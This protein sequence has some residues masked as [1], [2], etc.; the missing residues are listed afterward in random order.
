VSSYW[1]GAA[2]YY[3]GI[4]K[5]L[6]R[7]GH[8]ITFAEPDAYGRQEHRDEGDFSYV[9]SVVYR[10]GADVERMV[11][12]AA[13][14]DVV[15]KHSGIGVDDEILEQFIAGVA[16][17]KPCFFWD[18]DSPATLARVRANPDD[19]FREAIP[20]FTGILSYGGG[21]AS[22]SGYL[23]LGARAYSAIY[24]G[25]DPETH[26]PAAHD[27]TVSCDIAFLGNR[28]P[29]REERVDELF[30][31]AARLAPEKSFLLGGEGWA[32]KPLPANVR[33]IGH[34]PTGDHN[35]INSSA[36][37]VMNINRTSM[38]VSGFSPPTRVFEV[39]GS[40][41]CMVCDNWPG[42]EECFE[43]GREILVVNNAEDV[44]D[45]LRRLTDSD[46]TKIGKAFRARALRDHTYALRA[47]QAEAAFLDGMSRHVPEPQEAAA[48]L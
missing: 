22:R 6:T 27:P 19:P 5:Y 38:A 15:V 44:V 30:L 24:N 37:L 42:I 26:F 34:V 18:V 4:Y 7:R 12:R 33:W 46:R 47:A 21:P 43:P 13:S 23:A 36:R 16:S 29:D 25:L 2:T 17:R 48:Q 32:G 9:E 28:L 31:K 45:L 11:D 8:C 1:N 41:A 10:P 35:R 3:R 20:R 14:N 40:G 39:A